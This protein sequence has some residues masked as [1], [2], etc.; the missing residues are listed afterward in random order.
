MQ[1]EAAFFAV[2]HLRVF[3]FEFVQR[4]EGDRALQFEL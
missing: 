3:L 2:V 4:K 1:E